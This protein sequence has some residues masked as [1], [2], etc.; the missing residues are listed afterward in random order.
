MLVLGDKEVE[1]DKVAVRHH[2]DGDLGAMS[3]EDLSARML[4]EVGA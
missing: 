4:A 3:V 1:S 2:G